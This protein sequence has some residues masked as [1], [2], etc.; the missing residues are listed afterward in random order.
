MLDNFS[1][2]MIR[3]QAGPIA[4]WSN[5]SCNLGCG[6]GDPSLNPGKGWQTKYTP[7]YLC[8]FEISDQG[9]LG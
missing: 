6:R 7:Y 3:I 9:I 8:I 1:T 2:V 4:E 5:S